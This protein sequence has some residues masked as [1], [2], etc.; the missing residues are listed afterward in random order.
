MSS[1][2]EYV[3]TVK[4]HLES[5]DGEIEHFDA[6][7]DIILLKLEERYYE[8]LRTLR[9]Q[10]QGIRDNLLKLNAAGED[11]WVSLK[12]CLDKASSDMEQTLSVAAR[13]IR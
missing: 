8:L 4:C 12:S 13:E 11:S 7:A 1:K 6:R 5:W 3:E 9:T 2:D 10:E